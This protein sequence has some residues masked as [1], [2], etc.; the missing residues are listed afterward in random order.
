MQ[1][2]LASLA[3]NRYLYR[4]L[5]PKSFLAPHGPPMAPQFPSDYF[6]NTL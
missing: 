6:A 4:Y 1:M 3:E 5:E 2:S